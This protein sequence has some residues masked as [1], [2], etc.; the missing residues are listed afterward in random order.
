M[1]LSQL[2]RARL[3]IEGGT[4]VAEAIERITTKA[5]FRRMPALE[6]ALKSWTAARLEQAMAQLAQAGLHT[7]QLS[8]SA[9]A[10][11]DPVASRAL[12]AVAQAARRKT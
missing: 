12:L 8:G 4:P 2:H 10:L 3:A 11:A 1:Q 7:R 6:A 9:A 5:Q